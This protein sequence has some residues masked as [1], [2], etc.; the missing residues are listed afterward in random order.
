MLYIGYLIFKICDSSANVKKTK[1]FDSISDE[2]FKKFC[3]D[4]LSTDGYRDAKVISPEKTEVTAVSKGD[5]YV[6]DCKRIPANKLITKEDI[7]D[8]YSK[9]IHYK[10]DYAG[11]MTN[12]YFSVESLE[13][14][15]TLGVLTWGRN[16]LVK[17]TNQNRR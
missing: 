7:R 13:C 9:K 4:V 12:G 1:D 11:I 2:K 5:L 3:A 6:V 8:V 10:A 16:Y 15:N 14:A 17:R